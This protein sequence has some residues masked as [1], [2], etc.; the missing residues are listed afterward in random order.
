MATDRYGRHGSA[1]A[2]HSWGLGSSASP[3]RSRKATRTP[4]SPT[5]KTSG[6]FSAKI[7]NISAVQTPTPLTEVSR[8]TIASS[9]QVSISSS[10]T[11]PSWTAWD[12]FR[13]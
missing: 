4:R 8:A 11:V 3:Y 9:S 7:R 10:G 6:R 12:R 1:R 5:G 2:R 13:T